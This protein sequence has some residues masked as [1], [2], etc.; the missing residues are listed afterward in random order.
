MVK[1]RRIVLDEDVE[2]DGDVDDEIENRTDSSS[3]CFLRSGPIPY[4]R[5]HILINVLR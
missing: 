2:A 4:R 5:L 3:C 1:Q